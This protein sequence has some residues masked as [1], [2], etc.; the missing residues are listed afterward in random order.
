MSLIFTELYNFEVQGA[1][2]RSRAAVN[3]VRKHHQ[4]CELLY[5]SG[6]GI[7]TYQ[8]SEYR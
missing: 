1:I 4:S 5:Y 8:D 3:A 7:E 6:T 2:F